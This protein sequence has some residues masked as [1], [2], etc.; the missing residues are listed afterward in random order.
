MLEDDVHADDIY[1][2]C[3]D[4]LTDMLED[5]VIRNTINDN[6]DDLEKI[7]SELIRQSNDSGGN[8]NISAILA[9]PGKAVAAGNGLF[10]RFFGLSS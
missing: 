10:S 4:G 7:A 3:S 9:R 6:S 1:L 2:L 5:E 8:D